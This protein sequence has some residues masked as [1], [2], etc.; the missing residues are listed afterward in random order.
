LIALTVAALAVTVWSYQYF[1]K[2]QP[3][4]SL[5]NQQNGSPFSQIGLTI[6]NASIVV[7]SGGKRRFQVAAR[8]VTYSRD[9]RI[10]TVDTLRNGLLYDANE[11]P[12]VKFDAGRIVYET[13][14]GDI[15]TT[16]GAYV[17]LTGGIDATTYTPNGPRLRADQLSWNAVKSQV[18]VPGQVD[19]TFARRS[20][21]AVASDVIYDTQTHNLTVQHVHGTFHASKLVQ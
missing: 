1:G 4:A 21:D 20:G 10:I 16:A 8:E 14:S 15:S 17:Q 7:R 19:I 5:M 6:D 2:Y 12:Q 3:F 11:R 18:V 9:H 13:P